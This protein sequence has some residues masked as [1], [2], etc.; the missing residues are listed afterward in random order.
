MTIRHQCSERGCYKEQLPDWAILDG[1]FP[2]G[3]RPSDVDGIVEIN[4]SVLMLE[5]KP[6]MGALTKGQLLLFQNMTSGSPKVQ[7]L[8]IYGDTGVPGEIELYQHGAIKFRQPCDTSFLR[9]FCQQWGLFA[10]KE[11]THVERGI[12]PLIKPNAPRQ[13]PLLLNRHRSNHNSK[14]SEGYA[15]TLN[16]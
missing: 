15:Y 14:A 16:Q 7:V 9:W 4:Q 5:W 6:R 1:C 2:R 13:L 10:E 11:P 3:I 12:D 8:V